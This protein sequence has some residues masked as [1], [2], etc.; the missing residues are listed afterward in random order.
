MMERRYRRLV[1]LLLGSWLIVVGLASVIRAGLPYRA[2]IPA[3]LAVVVGL[4]LMRVR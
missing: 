3:A 1:V 4:L 2:E